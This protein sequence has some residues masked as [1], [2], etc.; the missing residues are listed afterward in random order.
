MKSLSIVIPFFN[1]ENR[2]GTTLQDVL[3]Y[4]K[5]WKTPWE[6]ILV[7]DHSTDNSVEVIN[8]VT[9]GVKNVYIIENNGK[10]G[11][12]AAVK[13][14]VIFAKYDWI[15]FM[16]ADNSTRIIELE[17]CIPLLNQNI[18]IVIGSRILPE[19]KIISR[20]YF[21]RYT[22]GKLFKFIR[23]IMFPFDNIHDTQCG[24]KCFT[25]NSAKEIFKRQT[26]TGFVFDLEILFIA[27]RLEFSIKEVPITWKNHPE[28]KITMKKIIE[29]ITEFLK[30][31]MNIIRRKY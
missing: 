13:E 19:S 18:Q 27:F 30:I 23:K 14:G 11:K 28:S 21:F 20:Q 4:C 6:L 2:I 15:I 1:E 22:L 12:G 25:K 8:Q 7:N 29:C 16:D 24:F 31:I 9:K 10:Q 5:H 3:D 26:T 17:K